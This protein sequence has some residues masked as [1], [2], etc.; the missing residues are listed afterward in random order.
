MR[1]II[2][3]IALV[4]LLSASASA[5]KLTGQV[6]EAASSQPIPGATVQVKR[7]QAGTL[8]NVAGT[9]TLTNLQP[10][11]TIVFMSLG[12]ESRKILYTGQPNLTVK[13]V[14][15]LA[16]NEV[17]VTALGLERNAQTLGYAVQKVDGR[18]VS[19]VKAANFLDNLAG[20]VAGVMVTAGT[21]GVGASSRI[22]I[23]GESSPFCGRRHC[24]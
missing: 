21:T 11:D 4:S 22:T 12:Y 23:R 9:F 10:A 20:K 6:V 13:L 5:Q 7:T 8:T 1:Q 3:L 24:D 14:A 2:P 19:E 17:V 16:L 15:G 18:Q